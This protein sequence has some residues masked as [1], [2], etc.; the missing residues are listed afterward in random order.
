MNIFKKVRG[1]KRYIKVYKKP[2]IFGIGVNK[3]GTTSLKLAMKDL[4]YTIGYQR[5]AEVLVE[6]WGRRNFKRIIRFCYSAEFFQDVPF[7]LPYTFQALDTEFPDSKFIL[8]VR[9][10]SEEWYSSI[11]RFH[12]KKWGKDNKIPS[13]E[14]LQK[15]NYRGIGR[16]W[17][18][19]RL[20]YNSPETD[21]YNKTSL[22]KF[23]E[24]HN[25]VVID[26]FKNRPEKLLVINLT[27]KN[28]Y[29]KL[30]TFL[31]VSPKS[32]GFPWANRT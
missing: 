12:A 9:N 23:Y 10:S 22:I 27:E 13:R 24:T 7:S 3:T 29:G 1:V 32:A 26:Y 19:N 4:G 20:Y 28:S 14:D 17:R 18:M 30:C 8:T 21:P 31:G 5:K 25:Q 6:D 2:K 11:T 16:P 15:A